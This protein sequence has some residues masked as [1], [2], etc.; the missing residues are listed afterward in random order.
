MLSRLD[1]RFSA[2]RDASEPLWRS[3]KTC[4]ADVA[5]GSLSL[6]PRRQGHGAS[7]SSSTPPPRLDAAAEAVQVMLIGI[8]GEPFDEES[9]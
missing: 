2:R 7:S 9:T 4:S 5:I 8:G 3:F 1:R 6:C